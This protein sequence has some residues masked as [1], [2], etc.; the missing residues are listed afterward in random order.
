MAWVNILEEDVV[1][2]PEV[3][4]KYLDSGIK[5]GLDYRGFEV[6]ILRIV[7]EYTVARMTRSPLA[8]PLCEGATVGI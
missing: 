7:V 4:W 3:S 8:V 5:V 6:N 2:E 1:G